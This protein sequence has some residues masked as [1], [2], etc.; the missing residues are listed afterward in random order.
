MPQTIAPTPPPR[1]SPPPPPTGM[2]TAPPPVARVVR[3]LERRESLVVGGVFNAVEGF[4]KTT[5]AAH[6]PSPMI[7]MAE[8][9]Y[10]TLLD[11]GRVP[12]V[13]AAAVT[14]WRDAIGWVDSLIENRQGVQTL[15][16]DALGGFERMCQEYICAA[17][18]GNDWGERG[19]GSFQKGYE[20]SA[21]E[22]LKLLARLDRLRTNGVSTWI[23]GH[24]NVTTFKNPEGAD[25]DQFTAA[26]HRK[27]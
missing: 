25:Y 1:R 22:W 2:P 15:F 23:L 20:L 18:F 19:F 6:A 7:L 17:E 16:L 3:P 14:D 11:A 27:T 26:C 24:V 9:G 4:G 10:Q 21:G 8:Q 5:F 13:P 12:Q